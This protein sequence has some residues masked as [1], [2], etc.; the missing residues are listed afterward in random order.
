MRTVER[1]V[2]LDRIHYGR[3]AR[4]VRA[5]SCKGN[6]MYGWNAPTCSSDENLNV[7][8]PLYDVC[9]VWAV[10]RSRNLQLVNFV[11]YSL[12]DFLAESF[13]L[14][15]GNKLHD[16]NKSREEQANSVGSD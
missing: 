10:D 5:G 1:R 15:S 11:A 7:S 3:V 2:Y 8:R 6:A 12:G 14:A 9:D 16:Q 4:Q 13:F